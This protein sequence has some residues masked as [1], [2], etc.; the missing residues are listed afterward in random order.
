MPGE[1]TTISTNRD[2][3]STPTHSDEA[4]T[5]SVLAIMNSPT[6]TTKLVCIARAALRAFELS[7][8]NRQIG[9]PGCS[10]DVYRLVNA[11]L[12]G[13]KIS[14]G[15][16]YTVSAII[17]AA[18]CHG[19]I[20]NLTILAQEWLFCLLWPIKKAFKNTEH[21]AF[22]LIRPIFHDA[23]VGRR[24]FFRDAVAERDGHQCVMTHLWDIEYKYAPKIENPEY[25][26][27]DAARILRRSISTLPATL[28]LL[29]H[30]AALPKD[31]V[32][33]F[34]AQLDAPENGMMLRV[35]LHIAYDRFWFCLLAT[36]E[37]NVYTIRWF[38]DVPTAAA[39]VR[40]VRFTNHSRHGTPLPNPKFIAIHAAIAHVLH[41]SGAGEVI[42]AVIDRFFENG[43]V[44][45]DRVADDDD[46]ALRMSLLDIDTH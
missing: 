6:Q 21:D 13:A 39:G 44:P 20:H 19:G 29:R 32:D 23:E 43:V 12:E 16:R 24:I 8:M 10:I 36:E 17:A 5:A 31:L 7:G 4:F 22:E 46:M 30:F 15:E 28:D 9:V 40:E 3:S 37:I 11:M 34:S 42:D 26:C 41:L 18:G 2:A 45:A 1:D 38:S 35:E 27:L 33:D 25:T 14:G